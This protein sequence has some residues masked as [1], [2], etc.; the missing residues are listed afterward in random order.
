MLV[1][2]LSGDPEIEIAGVAKD[3]REAVELAKSLR[4]DVITMDILMPHLD[5]FEATKRIM[6]EAPTPIVI[7]SA[8]VDSDAVEISMRALGL[9]ALAVI[10]KPVTTRSPVFEQVCRHLVA[11]VK[12]MAKVRV[13]RQWPDRSSVVRDTAADRRLPRRRYKMIAIAAS[14]GGPA[15]LHRLFGDLPA[16]LRLPILVVQHIADGFVGGFA[17]WLNAASGLRIKVAQDGEPLQPNCVYVAPDDR[18]LGV[19]RRSAI[20]LSSAD[21]I[22]GFRPSGSFLF[23]SVANAY[24]PSA[25]SVI[26]TGMGRDGVEGLKAVRAVGGTILAQDEASSTVFGM[27]GAAIAAGVA[28]AVLPLGAIAPHIAD[29]I[30]E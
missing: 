15:A 10:G 29:L 18:H 6:V 13:V 21:A 4:P 7:I 12:A 23:E 11:T 22:D 28:D 14:T 30:A 9:G 19:S 1:A 27:P 26:L 8:V 5:G 25:L 16:N 2:L 3:G 24:G 20:L 17:E